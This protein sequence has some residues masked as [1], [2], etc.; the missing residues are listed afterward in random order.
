M[1]TS[2]VN[3]IQKDSYCNCCSGRDSILVY[4]ESG[5]LSVS[6]HPTIAAPYQSES[7]YIMNP[8][9]TSFQSK[10]VT[11]K[12]LSN[13]DL[14]M[15]IVL[16]Q[17][18]NDGGLFQWSTTLTL[19]EGFTSNCIISLKNFISYCYSSLLTRFYIKKYFSTHFVEFI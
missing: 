4:F 8:L 19:K 9:I 6:R 7:F 14:K 10:F 5:Y 12:Y 3:T 15:S 1:G 17:I 16:E 13:L 11:W 18:T 2:E